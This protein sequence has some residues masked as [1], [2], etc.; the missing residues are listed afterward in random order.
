NG[1]ALTGGCSRDEMSAAAGHSG[2]RDRPHGDA[3]PQPHRAKSVIADADAAAATP[4]TKLRAPYSHG[5]TAGRPAP[6][7]S[8]TARA[9]SLRQISLRDAPEVLR[10]FGRR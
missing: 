9:V 3:D 7:S 5:F 1:R 8:R 6:A 4:T 10:D 2:K